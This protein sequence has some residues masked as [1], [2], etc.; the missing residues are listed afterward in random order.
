[1]AEDDASG[2]LEEM[3]NNCIFC[4]I[5]SKEMESSVV[6]ED[7]N[8]LAFLDI[9]PAVP[10][11]IILITKEHYQIFPQVPD[12]IVSK[13]FSS[14][15]ILS[16]AILQALSSMGVSGTSIFIANGGAAGQRAP[17]FMMHIIPRKS[18][19]KILKAERNK[20]DEK[21]IYSFSKDFREYFHTS[22]GLSYDEM[23]FM[24]SADEPNTESNT[25]ANDKITSKDSN[26]E[27]D[28]DDISRRLI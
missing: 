21:E 1:M 3:K 28:L 18:G 19:D 4:K 5:A 12:E 7:A 27:Y 22:L 24:D 2:Q 11:H 6:Y 9:R 20:V 17:H 14:A 26:D 23:L 8:L 13:M 15:R 25:Q 16:M 10:G